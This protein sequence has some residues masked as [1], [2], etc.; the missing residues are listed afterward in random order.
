MVI[1]WRGLAGSV[2]VHRT[3]DAPSASVIPQ[4][5]L[6]PCGFVRYP[7]L[8]THVKEFEGFVALIRL[9]PSGVRG[10]REAGSVFLACLAMLRMAVS[11]HGVLPVLS[12]AERYAWARGRLGLAVPELYA[13]VPDA[14]DSRA[15]LDP[16]QRGRASVGVAEECYLVDPAS[17]HMLVSK[18][19]PCMSKY[20]R[21]VQ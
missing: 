4:A 8:L 21:L 16:A 13:F 6:L 2:L 11:A 5:L 19:K 7:V 20:A 3:V 1:G 15:R 9:A 10:G 12:D 18:I 14:N 17:S